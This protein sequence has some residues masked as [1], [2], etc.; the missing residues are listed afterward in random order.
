MAGSTPLE[1]SRA[2]SWKKSILPTL[3]VV[4]ACYINPT[5]YC[6]GFQVRRVFGALSYKAFRNNRLCSG[7]SGKGSENV[8]RYQ[9]PDDKDVDSSVKVLIDETKEKVLDSTF[10]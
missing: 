8:S 4:G 7:I 5:Y 10:I 6:F 9:F 2:L 3:L 1:P